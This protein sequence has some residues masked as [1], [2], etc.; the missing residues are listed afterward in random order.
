MDIIKAIAKS[1]DLG[2]Q[3][4]TY[5]EINA[6][7]DRHDKTELPAVCELMALKGSFEL[8]YESAKDNQTV[9][10]LFL[11][12]DQKTVDSKKTGEIVDRMKSVALGFITALNQAGEFETI[13]GTTLE[14]YTIVKQ[15]DKCLSGI[16]ITIPLKPVKAACL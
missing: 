2:Y 11:D 5:R 9:C 8:K 1:L 10:L 7:F 16:E 6:L 13:D 15:F 3:F 12:L 14:Y 4:G